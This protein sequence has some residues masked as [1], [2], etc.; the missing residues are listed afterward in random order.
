[1][2]DQA[3]RS[4][5]SPQILPHSPAAPRLQHQLLAE[6]VGTAA[7]LCAVIGSGIMAEAL[8]GGNNAVAL[9]ANTLVTV[10]ALYVLIEILGPISG[11]HF[12]PLVSLVLWSKGTAAHLARPWVATLFI[13]FQL[14]GAVAGAWA[15]HAM[16]DLNLLQFS[17]KLRGGWN[18]AGQFSG[19]GQW[20]AETVATAGLI[21][22]VLRAPPNK[23]PALVA[24]YIGAAYW[25]T[26]STSFANPA[27]VLGRMLTDSFAGIAPASAPGFVLAEAVGAGFGVLLNRWLGACRT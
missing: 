5:H 4:A 26:A 17:H 12:N 24:C 23:A 6:F 2:P 3:I 18:A 20:I 9:L 27:A 11:A 7:L 1:M 8:S 15:A 16:F 21:L 14:L 10:F 25:F 19:W 13:A 22:V